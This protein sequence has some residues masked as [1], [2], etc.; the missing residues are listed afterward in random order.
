[1]YLRDVPLGR[2][3]DDVYVPTSSLRID[4]A[5]YYAGVAVRKMQRS[6]KGR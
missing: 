4:G 1:M 5:L 2:D 3:G 6:L